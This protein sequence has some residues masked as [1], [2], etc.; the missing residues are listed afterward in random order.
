MQHVVRRVNQ[1]L[2]RQEYVDASGEDHHQSAREKAFAPDHRSHDNARD[3]RHEADD[4]FHSQDRILET[5]ELLLLQLLAFFVRFLHTLT[6]ATMNT[7][8]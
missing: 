4:D 6:P 7:S 1:F 3:N 5:A 8:S 2:E